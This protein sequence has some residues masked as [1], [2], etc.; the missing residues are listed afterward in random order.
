MERRK[1]LFSFLIK[2]VVIHELRIVNKHEIKC[3]IH[4]EKTVLS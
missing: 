1:H 3:R 2:Y 4:L